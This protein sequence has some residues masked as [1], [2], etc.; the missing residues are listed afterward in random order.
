MLTWISHLGEECVCVCM[1]VLEE[2]ASELKD[3]LEPF[4]YLSRGKLIT[5]SL[6]T[7][8]FCIDFSHGICNFLKRNLSHSISLG[9]SLRA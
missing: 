9:S 2:G 7:S 5:P 8:L 3:L 6:H 1:C 4:S